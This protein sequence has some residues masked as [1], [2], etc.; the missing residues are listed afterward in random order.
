SAPVS[1]LSNRLVVVAPSAV[2]RPSGRIDSPATLTDPQFRRIAIGD[3]TGVP[4]GVYARTYLESIS[5]WEA[6]SERMV[7]TRSVRA[8]LAIVE[9]G[10]VD[11]GIVYRTDARTTDGVRVVFD[12]AA[13]DGPAIVY[14][15][16]VLSGARDRDTAEQFLSFLQRPASGAVFDEAGFVLLSP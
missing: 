6:L 11:A 8:A 2:F 9:A 12:V 5:L 3:P 7:P 10:E 15:A 16:A 14:P 13:E 1:L 4:A